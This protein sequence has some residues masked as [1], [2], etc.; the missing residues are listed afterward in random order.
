MHFMQSTSYV[1]VCIE[2]LSPSVHTGL[3][4]ALRESEASSEQDD[5]SPGQ[6]LLDAVLP[7]PL[8]D[9]RHGARVAHRH[10]W[11]KAVTH[12]RGKIQIIQ[13]VEKLIDRYY[14]A[15]STCNRDCARLYQKFSLFTK[16]DK[17]HDRS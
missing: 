1:A 5:D 17:N 14:V 15:K 13:H 6:P 8:Q 12:L 2:Y 7:A 11:P 10:Q 3:L 9:R 4:T 16:I